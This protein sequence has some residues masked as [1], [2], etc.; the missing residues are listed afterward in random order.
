MPEKIQ[1][2]KLGKGMEGSSGFNDLGIIEFVLENPS[3]SVRSIVSHFEAYKDNAGIFRKKYLLPLVKGG[4]LIEREN[5]KVVGRG[6]PYIYFVNPSRFLVANGRELNVM[7]VRSHFY[8]AF[9][10][11]RRVYAPVDAVTFSVSYLLMRPDVKALYKINK[12]FVKLVPYFYPLE[13]VK[14]MLVNQYGNALSKIALLESLKEKR[15]IAPRL[16]SG[17]FVMF[18]PG[19]KATAELLFMDMPIIEFHWIS[20]Y[21]IKSN[22][23]VDIGLLEEIGRITAIYDYTSWTKAL[24]SVIQ[25]FG[26]GGVVFKV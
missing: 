15:S 4:Y 22:L 18:N 2:M 17:D 3:C 8:D 5:R 25:Y 24:K 14:R 11:G 10:L 16:P 21:G 6:L 1:V 9:I 7:D 12:R 19:H 20:N 26:I 23:I 13:A